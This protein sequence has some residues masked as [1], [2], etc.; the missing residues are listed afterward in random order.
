LGFN[1][2][3][4][5]TTEARAV[6]LDDVQEA[7][8]GELLQRGLRWRLY[9]GPP[10][11][12]LSLLFIVFDSTPWRRWAIGGLVVLVVVRL[13]MAAPLVRRYGFSRAIAPRLLSVPVLMLLGTVSLSGGVESPLFPLVPLVGGFLAL[14]MG[15]R[16]AFTWVGISTAVLW[17]LAVLHWWRL[18]PNLVPEVFGGTESL[19]NGGLLLTK[20]VM[21]NI[22]FLWGA[23]MGWLMRDAYRSAMVRALAARDEVLATHAESTKQLTTLAAEIAHELKN[24]LA[25]VKGLAALLEKDV[26]GR[27]K[28]RLVVLRREVDRMQDIL[29]SFLNFSRPLVPLDAQAVSLKDVVENVVALHEGLA[30]EKGVSFNVEDWGHP[31]VKADPRKVK[32]VLINL[33]QNAL[34]ASPRGGVVDVLVARDGE[35]GARVLVRDRGPGLD[36]AKL[37]RVFEPGVTTKATGSGLGLTVARL[38]ARQH[39]GEVTL[40]PRDD[41]AGT[42]AT[43][44]LPGEPRAATEASA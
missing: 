43:L 31:Q 24:P 44:V 25:S 6:A 12:F 10:L 40:G 32:Q 11:V 36:A 1:L 23:G 16:L 42:V 39:G 41:G 27:A 35:A 28:E 18:V 14:F 19:S 13:A 34:D 20:A 21:L 8:L 5:S 4:V 33:V 3:A 15:A 29:D 30:R 17:T 2:T 9:F 38:L 7:V 26:D 22:A 37:E